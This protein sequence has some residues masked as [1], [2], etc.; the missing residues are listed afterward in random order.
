MSLTQVKILCPI[1]KMPFLD[2]VKD[3]ELNYSCIEDLL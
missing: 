2:K 1:C 3:I